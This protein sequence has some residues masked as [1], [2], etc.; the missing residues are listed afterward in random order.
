MFEWLLGAPLIG[1]LTTAGF[2]TFL[3]IGHN[4]KLRKMKKE[5]KNQP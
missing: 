4:L 2:F 1:I 5:R 3:I